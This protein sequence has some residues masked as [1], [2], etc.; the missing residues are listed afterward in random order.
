MVK[1]MVKSM[2]TSMATSKNKTGYIS[3]QESMKKGQGTVSIRGWVHRERGS[4]KL[5]FIVLRDS[6]GL[7]QCVF[8]R[9]L[10]EKE[11][12]DID[13]TQVE[14]SI[15][16]TG[17]IKEDK[18][19]PTGYELQVSSFEIVGTSDQFPIKKDIMRQEKRQL[20]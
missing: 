20:L 8:K 16:L 1:S 11:W 5:K 17:D 9:D 15:M 7:V 6:T 19:A 2:T 12:D 3:I 18:R 14:T 10:F 4:N 13:K